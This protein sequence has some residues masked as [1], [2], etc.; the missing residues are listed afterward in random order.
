[1]KVI[2][3]DDEKP[4]LINFKMTAER[5]PQISELH[6]FLSASEAN[7]FLLNNAADVVFMDMD[8][9]GAELDAAKQLRKEHPTLPIIGMISVDATDNIGLSPVGWLFKPYTANEVSV[10]LHNYIG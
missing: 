8:L 6:L 1:M 9:A 2:Y 7:T 5:L 10:V 4:A 3:I